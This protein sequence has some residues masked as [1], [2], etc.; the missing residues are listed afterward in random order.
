M[1][2]LPKQTLQLHHEAEHSVALG[3]ETDARSIL[4]IKQTA[5]LH[6]TQ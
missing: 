5:E 3:L 6:S 2:F 1:P 4:I